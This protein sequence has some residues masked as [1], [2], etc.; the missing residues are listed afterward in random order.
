[1]SSSSGGADDGQGR[2]SAGV[3]GGGGGH[4]AGGNGVG[5]GGGADDG[6]G[7]G[8]A[9]R[10]GSAGGGMHGRDGH[11]GCLQRARA[12]AQRQSTL[13]GSAT[14]S[15]GLEA[16]VDRWRHKQEPQHSAGRANRASHVR[17]L[18]GKT[19]PRDP[20]TRTSMHSHATTVEGCA[21]QS[22]KSSPLTTQQGVVNRA[23]QASTQTKPTRG[24]AGT[25]KTSG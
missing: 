21:E 14:A 12:C 7:R 4:G 2:G 18:P 13:A 19:S 25:A 10:G 16:N 6:R 1:V 23:K 9:G 11:N 22:G 5:A 20:Q 3:S 24:S 15:E 8:S 17:R